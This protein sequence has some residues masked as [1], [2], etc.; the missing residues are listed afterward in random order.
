MAM[1]MPISRV[2]R[3]AATRI[4]LATRTP[5]L[6][7]PRVELAALQQGR[8]HRVNISPTHLVQ[9][10]GRRTARLH[11]GSERRHG[12]AIVVEILCG[13]LACERSPP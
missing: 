4:L 5:S 13:E 2:R 11:R 1:R 12:T 10:G 8:L 6:F 3:I 7:V 9:D